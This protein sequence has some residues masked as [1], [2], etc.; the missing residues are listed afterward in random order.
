MRR[1]AIGTALALSI[2]LGFGWETSADIYIWTDERGIVHMTD[3]WDNVPAPRR[4]D[5]TVRESTPRWEHVSPPPTRSEVTPVEPL[6]PRQLP[7]QTA[8]DLAE[9]PAVTVAPAS[10]PHSHIAVSKHR[11][12]IHRPKRVEPP[13][14]HNVRLDP[15]DS[16]F[17]WVGP[18][19]VPQDTF[20]YPRIPLE[21]QAQFRERI[22]QLEQRR[23]VP[24][25]PVQLRSLR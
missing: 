10:S 23:S 15:F 18:N 6:T 8:P 11:R 3:Q 14:P 2:I 21:K 16:N 25:K 4:A 7:L 1:R 9:T 5:V 19:R 17:V 22:R 20:T 12:F 24:E 13:F